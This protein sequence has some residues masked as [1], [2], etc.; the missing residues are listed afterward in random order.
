MCKHSAHVIKGHHRQNIDEMEIW[1]ISLQIFHHNEAWHLKLDD[2]I[3]SE[4]LAQ[5]S[6]NSS[7]LA[8]LY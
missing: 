1:L 7:A 3:H 6:S 8:F 2:A 5:D 4:G